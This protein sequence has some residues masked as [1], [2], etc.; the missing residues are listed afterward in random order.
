MSGVPFEGLEEE[1]QSALLKAGWLDVEVVAWPRFCK[2][3]WLVRARLHNS[4]VGVVA[5]VKVEP[6]LLTLQRA[7][8]R[9]PKDASSARLNDRVY[10]GPDVVLL[11][12]AVPEPDAAATQLDGEGDTRTEGSQEDS[13]QATANVR[14]PSKRQTSPSQRNRA[15]KLNSGISP[16]TKKNLNSEFDLLDTLPNGSCG[17]S[18][19]AVGAALLRG[20][21]VEHTVAAYRVLAPS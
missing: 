14:G 21:T 6:H 13:A 16:G 1:L 12:D 19:L 3:P 10:R 17:Y 15:K 18:S 2:Q 4:L 8:Q 20:D 9:K 5:A 11:P 7:T